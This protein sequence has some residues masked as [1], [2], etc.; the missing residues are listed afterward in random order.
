[1]NTV[2]ITGTSNQLP[3]SKI[4]SMTV[5]KILRKAAETEHDSLSYLLA[6][7]AALHNA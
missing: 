3:K 2:T 4:S 6:C 7:T 1:M 5:Y